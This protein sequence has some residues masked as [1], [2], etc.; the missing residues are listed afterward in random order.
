MTMTKRKVSVSLDADLVDE[1]EEGG[2]ALSAQVNEA[3][4]RE[5]EHRRRQRHLGEFLDRLD[6]E[7]GP[8]DEVLVEHYMDLLR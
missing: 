3:I 4:R 1:L 5:L 6:A 2:T 7:H 8:P